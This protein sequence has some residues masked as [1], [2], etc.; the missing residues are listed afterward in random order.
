MSTMIAPRPALRLAHLGYDLLRAAVWPIGVGARLLLIQDNRVLL[1][2]HSYLN[3]WHLPGG[4]MKR[5]ETLADAARREAYEE[6]GAVVLGELRLLGL[7]T[8]ATRGRTD[9]TAVFVCEEFGLQKPTDRWE[10][11]GRAFFDLDNL[12]PNLS[13]GYRRV[14]AHYRQ[15]GPPV[16]GVW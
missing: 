7:Y 6:A 11:I 9:H 14:M 1:V 13:R 2:Y 12:P 5:R 4:G 16:V 3:N 8:G 15:G 10:I